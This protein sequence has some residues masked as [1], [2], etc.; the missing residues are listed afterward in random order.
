MDENNNDISL[1]LQHNTRD[2]EEKQGNSI[3]MT[4][5]SLLKKELRCFE[6][7]HPESAESKN[8]D[9]KFDKTNSINWDRFIPQ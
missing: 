7:K 5:W 3:K 1:I 2:E 8:A 6:E 9:F 4:L